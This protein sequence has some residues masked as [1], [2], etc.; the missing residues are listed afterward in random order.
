MGDWGLAMKMLRARVGATWSVT[1]LCVGAGTLAWG[2]SYPAKA[3]RFIVPFAPGGGTD[4]IARVL[5]QHLT[6]VMT[7]RSL[8][9]WRHRRRQPV[10][11]TD[12]IGQIR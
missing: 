11:E 7:A 6:A 9:G 12:P 5:S 8:L 3:I 2:Q 1:M 10:G 4:L